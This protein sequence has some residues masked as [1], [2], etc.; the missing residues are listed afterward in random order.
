MGTYL[1]DVR[2]DFDEI[3]YGYI[4]DHE[5]RGDIVDSLVKE[6]VTSY[7]NGKR[8]GAKKSKRVGR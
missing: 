7:K 8:D 5:E 2:E 6:V 3:L 1:D 4:P